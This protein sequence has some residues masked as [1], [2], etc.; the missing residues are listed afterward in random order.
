[1][2]QVQLKYRRVN[3][4]H[5]NGEEVTGGKVYITPVSRWGTSDGLMTT[6]TAEHA[7]GDTV[8]L[9]AG[10]YRFAL[11]AQNTRFEEFRIVPSTG[12]PF[13]IDQLT[14]FNTTQATASLP[15]WRAYFDDRIQQIILD[16][17]PVTPDSIVGSTEVGRDLLVA[18]DATVARTRLGLSAVNNTADVDK[19]ISAATQSALDDKV[20]STPALIQIGNLA[21][22]ESTILQV[23]SGAWNTRT[24]A[25][26]RDDMELDTAANLRARS[27]HTG[28]QSAD[29]LTDGTTNKAFTATERTK[30]SGVA[31]GATA[32]DT[33]ANLKS[34]ANHTGT[35]S[36]DTVVDGS[37][38]KAYTAS[39][40]TKLSGIASGATAN[41]TDANLKSR[42]NHTGTQ[43]AAT[44]SDF[45][46][47]I[48]THF[49]RVVHTGPRTKAGFIATLD[50]AEAK[51]KWTI[52]YFPGGSPYDLAD[53]VSLSGY[54]CQIRGDGCGI[55]GTTPYGTVFR[56]LSQNGPVLDF[57]GMQ[58]PAN[59]I[60]RLRHGGFLVE[61]SNVADATKANI[62]MKIGAVWG[63]K[64]SDIAIRRTGGPCIKIIPPS[65]GNACYFNEFSEIVCHTPVSAKA[66]DVPYFHAIEANGN[67][68]S[69]IG[70]RSSTSSDD[71]GVSGA[72]IIEGS[73][74]YPSHDNK[75][76]DWWYEYL[77]VPSG[78]C[79]F[80]LSGNANIIQDFQFF[81]LSKE[82][83]ATGTTH[84]R[85]L[86]STVVDQGGNM[87]RGQ[88]PGTWTSSPIVVDSGVEVR[89]SG[90]AVDGIKSYKGGNVILFSGIGR[91]SVRLIGALS[92]ATDLGWID[93]SGQTTNRLIDEAAQV[94]V[95]PTGWTGSPGKPAEV[96]LFTSSGTWTKPSG[97]VTVNVIA[98]GGGGGGGSG[99]RGASGSV[100]G[101]GGGGSAG[102]RADATLIASD[103]GSTV[104]VTIGAGGSSGAAVTANDTNGN[105]G[106]AGGQT[107]FG[108]L[109][110]APGGS[111]GSG[112]TTSGGTGGLSPLLGTT[113]SAMGAGAAGGT[114]AA[115]TG[116]NAALMGAAGGPGGGGISTTP[117]AFNG[118]GGANSRL[119][120]GG[121]GGSA[122][123]VDTTSPTS[124]TAPSAQGAPG[125]SGGGG[126]A[127]IT[128]AAQAGATSTGYGA[129]GAGGG[130][131][132]NGSNSGAGAPGTGGLCLVITTF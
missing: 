39:E 74:T 63:V 67:R 45:G 25:Q 94:E 50:A 76:S 8:T 129:G 69:G 93:N 131:A 78:G 21:P 116:V 43:T 75:F 123:V 23:K 28:T 11:V 61:G 1:M 81:D 103:L 29:T 101:G 44:I 56:A 27:S 10:S 110:V 125:Q 83:G 118:G 96:Q 98:L 90:N 70:F 108:G 4:T 73:A 32:N 85:L 35:Q 34:R 113:S 130:A 86:P 20:D 68:F 88:I 117:A 105:T 5:V 38:N 54:S 107:T 64:F 127:S 126:A 128:T 71:T 13:R 46:N 18:D 57:T 97:A 82:S 122:G 112:G 52:A 102:V 115:G 16:G 92:G 48:N 62:G 26:L 47:A 55:S 31:T 58:M 106:G 40:K 22:S 2:T 59:A 36:A 3:G 42:G 9:G 66:N 80:S 33:D 41:D 14:E 51:G 19:P 30:L 120:G 65:P 104:S 79:L 77:H 12:G 89:Q 121:V 124:G 109:V 87:I 17:A 95:R 111:G 15:Q 53:G 37:T 49:G 99:R 119:G 24:P 84:F 91:T 114:G 6:D 132:L 60:G 7:V 72:A 100:C